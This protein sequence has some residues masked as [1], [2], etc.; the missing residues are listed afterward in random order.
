MLCTPSTIGLPIHQYIK[1]L[2]KE[3]SLCIF[4][5]LPFCFFYIIIF[6]V[7]HYSEIAWI[8]KDMTGFFGYLSFWEHHNLLFQECELSAAPLPPHSRC[9]CLERHWTLMYC[10]FTGVLCAWGI[11]NTMQLSQQE[12]IPDKPVGHIS[13]ALFYTSL[14]RW[15]H[16]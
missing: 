15:L 6:S 4:V 14:S 2:K 10:A 12:T 16:L 3:L 7:E 5:V 9:T 1:G 8:R 13:P 11:K